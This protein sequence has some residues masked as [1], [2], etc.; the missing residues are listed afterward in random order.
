MRQFKKNQTSS[1]WLESKSLIVS[2]F[3]KYCP[4]Q[5]YVCFMSQCFTRKVLNGTNKQN[6]G[7]NNKSGGLL[8][9]SIDQLSF[10]MYLYALSI[11]VKESWC[12]ILDYWIIVPRENFWDRLLWLVC[13]SIQ[14]SILKISF[15]YWHWS[16]ISLCLRSQDLFNDWLSCI[17]IKS[18]DVNTL[19]SFLHYSWDQFSCQKWSIHKN[20]CGK[21]EIENKYLFIFISTTI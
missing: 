21:R 7:F 9:F 4:L 6:D 18:V 11:S 5:N 14:Q 2:F 17:C 10:E 3:Y 8:W 12:S 13:T 20:H 1:F 19:L 16:C 15:Y